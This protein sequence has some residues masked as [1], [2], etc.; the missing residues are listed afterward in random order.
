MR[1]RLAFAEDDLLPGNAMARARSQK[2]FELVGGQDAE[3][4]NFGQG[5]LGVDL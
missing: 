3:E 2:L 1:Q 5:F 4:W